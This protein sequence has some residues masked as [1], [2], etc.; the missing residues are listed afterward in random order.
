MHSRLLLALILPFFSMPFFLI[1]GMYLREKCMALTCLCLVVLRDWNSL[2]ESTA[3][4]SFKIV[5]AP[6]RDAGISVCEGQPVALYLHIF[7]TQ[8]KSGLPAAGL[9]WHVGWGQPTLWP[10]GRA[11]LR[12]CCSMLPIGPSATSSPA[13]FL[14]RAMRSPGICCHLPSGNCFQSSQ[15]CSVSPCSW[16]KDN[17]NK[18][19]LPATDSPSR[20]QWGVRHALMTWHSTVH[21]GLVS[22]RFWLGE[23]VWQVNKKHFYLLN[24]LFSE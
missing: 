22:K 17:F 14:S 9:C 21:P 24:C 13:L 19:V 5:S 15:V 1:Q 20:S 6:W 4:T 12:G 23:S 2:L 8:V 7:L 11:S 10:C 3:N 18:G 16:T